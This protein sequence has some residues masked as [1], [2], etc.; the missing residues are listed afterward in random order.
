MPGVASLGAMMETEAIEFFRTYDRIRRACNGIVMWKPATGGEVAGV[1]VALR[2]P[3]P[4]GGEGRQGGEYA[5]YKSK[6]I[7]DL[8]RLSTVDSPQ[9]SVLCHRA[10]CG[11]LTL[12]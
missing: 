10:S 1:D 3:H 5:L 9:T 12:R 4:S 2:A 6:F 8:Q 7:L 11:P